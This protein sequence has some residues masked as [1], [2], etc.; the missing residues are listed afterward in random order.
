MLY[1]A[2][3]PHVVRLTPESE[4][5]GARTLSGINTTSAGDDELI[6]IREVV[7]RPLDT[8]EKHTHLLPLCLLLEEALQL[9]IWCTNRKALQMLLFG[10]VVLS[11]YVLPTGCPNSSN[12]PIHPFIHSFNHPI[13]PSNKHLLKNYF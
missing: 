11:R 4:R 7:D 13:Y 1:K 2:L 10:S 8:G 5:W 6:T 12:I 3:Q 9:S